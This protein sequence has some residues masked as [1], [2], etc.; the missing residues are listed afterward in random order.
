MSLVPVSST[1]PTI[2]I[3]LPEQ[4]LSQF[5]QALHQLFKDLYQNVSHSLPKRQHN[6]PNF[7]DK[8]KD[9]FLQR[10][11]MLPSLLTG[12]SSFLSAKNFDILISGLNAEF[13]VMLKNMSLEDKTK[14]LHVALKKYN[15]DY[16][17]TLHPEVS[18]PVKHSKPK[19][20]A[21]KAH[22]QSL[23]ILPK[24]P[25]FASLDEGLDAL[26]LALEKQTAS[27][28]NKTKQ[29]LV[30]EQ[31]AKAFGSLPKTLK[32]PAEEVK[33]PPVPLSFAEIHFNLKQQFKDD[34]SSQNE[35]ALTALLHQRLE[36]TFPNL[37]E[38]VKPKPVV[39]VPPKATDPITMWCTRFDEAVASKK[40]GSIKVLLLRWFNE[41]EN[42]EELR[43][44]VKT[45][46]KAVGCISQLESFLTDH[47]LEPLKRLKTHFFDGAFS[48]LLLALNGQTDK[49]LAEG[50]VL[51]RRT[52]QLLFKIDASDDHAYMNKYLSIIRETPSLFD[53]ALYSD[54][55]LPHRS[56]V[57]SR[58]KPAPGETAAKV[59][60]TAEQLQKKEKALLVPIE[61]HTLTQRFPTFEEGLESLLKSL[62]NEIE[63]EHGFNSYKTIS[64]LF[65][66]TFDTLPEKL[67][68]PETDTHKAVERR[69][70]ISYESV[71][72]VLKEQFNEKL[73][74]L[75]EEVLCEALLKALKKTFPQYTQSVLSG[76]MAPQRE[77]DQW[78]DK[79]AAAKKTKDVGDKADTLKEWCRVVPTSS[80]LSDSTELWDLFY[81]IAQSIPFSRGNDPLSIA[82]DFP[83]GA[84]DAVI[85]ALASKAETVKTFYM[86]L[87]NR[88]SD[89]ENLALIIKHSNLADQHPALMNIEIFLFCITP[90]VPFLCYCEAAHLPLLKLFDK[91]PIDH[92][93]KEFLDSFLMLFSQLASHKPDATPD[94]FASL[95]PSLRSMMKKIGTFDSKELTYYLILLSGTQAAPLCDLAI[96]LSIPS[97]QAAARSKKLKMEELVLH[98][99]FYVST[100]GRALKH[101]SKEGF[102]LLWNKGLTQKWMN[103]LKVYQIDLSIFYVILLATAA[104]FAGPISKEI[105]PLNTLKPHL[106]EALQC[107]D[108]A[109][110]FV[111]ILLM[112]VYIT[113]DM[114][115]PDAALTLSNRLCTAI[116][117]ICKNIPYSKQNTKASGVMGH[118]L[119]WDIL[120]KVAKKA[121]VTPIYRLKYIAALFSIM[122]TLTKNAIYSNPGS[123]S[124]IL[125]SLL[126]AFNRGV[127]ESWERCDQHEAFLLSYL[128]SQLLINFFS[129]NDAMEHIKR[130]LPPNGQ[131]ISE[132]NDIQVD[133]TELFAFFEYAMAS[134]SDSVNV[135]VRNMQFSVEDL[136]PDKA[137]PI[138]TIL[139][140]T[141]IIFKA[142]WQ[143]PD[144][145]Q[146]LIRQAWNLRLDTYLSAA[147]LICSIFPDPNHAARKE[148][149][150]ILDSNFGQMIAYLETDLEKVGSKSPAERDRLKVDYEYIH[151]TI[152]R[153][154]TASR[155]GGTHAA[156]ITDK[157]I[158]LANCLLTTFAFSREETHSLTE[159][160]L[161]YMTHHPGIFINDELSIGYIFEIIIIATDPDY[162][163]GK[164]KIS[165]T[166]KAKNYANPLFDFLMSFIK[167]ENSPGAYQIALSLV[168]RYIQ[169]TASDR[170]NFKAIDHFITAIARGLSSKKPNPIDYD[171][172]IIQLF[173]MLIDRMCDDKQVDALVKAAPMKP[174]QT[175]QN[176]AL[177][178]LTKSRDPEL[179]LEARSLV[180]K[181]IKCG[182]IFNSLT[183]PGDTS[184]E[185]SKRRDDFRDKLYDFAIQCKAF[186][187]EKVLYTS[188]SDRLSKFLTES[189]AIMPQDESDSTKEIEGLKAMIELI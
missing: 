78:A 56:E 92:Y 42:N 76:R 63:H 120:R 147:D 161:N 136:G 21:A 141:C 180:A 43:L 16:Y 108:K 178:A 128:F 7:P 124:L 84:F 80:S 133:K 3:D 187:I 66:A 93:S 81:S 49:E 102:G 27:S 13:S 174:V 47:L 135:Q 123:Y 98:H 29:H 26:L 112:F 73:A 140:E 46:I 186:N 181:V 166:E 58:D 70:P 134:L 170:L 74:N 139:G 144:V 40:P 88:T 176:F 97:L 171:G 173:K 115:E 24:K 55:I 159:R 67:K 153:L 157:P 118:Q 14:H 142:V 25:M 90:R 31:F 87:L 163:P 103:E 51:L 149:Q 72:Y 132:S 156:I 105:D 116:T 165:G 131:K 48:P 110:D 172:V 96:E 59:D 32:S 117:L 10:F 20:T 109:D 75:G 184:A 189:L 9:K 19:S 99:K 12:T 137:H 65:I 54:V 114:H 154:L 155:R 129:P 104:K 164:T 162:E 5:N 101:C 50:K 89:E 183:K 146:T 53:L 169:H 60:R 106:Q 18:E 158:Q 130:I 94:T 2:E 45:W 64:N 113:T 71:L 138:Y 119:F 182:L 151:Q 28:I 62:G 175:L 4:T 160:L 168:N 30:T 38:V 22:K 122:T 167:R 44:S 36:Q 82:D 188:S 127:E 61:N 107:S 148:F 23:E 6:D 95:V 15:F 8:V 185:I 79:F 57:E 68:S 41:I 125:P 1:N 179:H 11:E 152:D 77:I 37:L 86:F 52:L 39:P 177:M 111:K 85:E 145:P 69:R 35:E 150:G 100:F 34:L 33:E 83:K 126:Q 91:Y 17:K 143:M 121:K